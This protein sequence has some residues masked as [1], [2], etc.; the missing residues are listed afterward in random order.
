MRLLFR[1]GLVVVHTT[2]NGNLIRLYVPVPPRPLQP[3][4]TPNYNTS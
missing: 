3:I 1:L 4:P 2:F